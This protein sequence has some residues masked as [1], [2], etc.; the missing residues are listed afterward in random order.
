MKNQYF[1]L[2][3]LYCT[4]LM[5]VQSCKQNISKDDYLSKVLANLDQIKSA[6]Y[7]SSISGSAPGDTTKFVTYEYYRKEYCNPADTFLGSS[8]FWLLP[9][10]TTKMYYFYNGLAQAYID[11]DR[12]TIAI[13]SFQTNRLPFRPIGP[14]FFNYTKNIIRYALET[15]DSI[16]TRFN[17]LGDS[18]HFSLAVYGDTHVEFFGKP[19]YSKNPYNTG[20]GVSGMISG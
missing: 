2:T 11:K 5:I 6:T 14:P 13:D 20:R 15:K 10:D 1:V 3:I 4:A 18:V 9:E 19:V 8:F 12:K 7:F 16:S 17:D